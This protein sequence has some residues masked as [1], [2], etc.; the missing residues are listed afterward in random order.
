MPITPPVRATPRI[1]SSV[2]LRLTL[3]VACTPPWLD[4]T[5]RRAIAR[6]S[7]THLWL[8]CATSTIIPS[9]SIRLTAS[10]PLSVSPPL[11]IPCIEPARSLSKKCVSEAIRKP[12][13]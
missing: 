7:A 1:S 10:R 2:R 6:M 3:Q 5:G 12:A 8:Q 9:A 11:S 4:T 13:A